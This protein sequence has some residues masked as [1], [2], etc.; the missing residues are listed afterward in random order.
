[1]YEKSLKDYRVL[2]NSSAQG[3][4]EGVWTDIELAYERA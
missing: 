2:K 4:V 3:E 1:M